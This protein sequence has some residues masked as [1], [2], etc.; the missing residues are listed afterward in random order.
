[1]AIDAVSL[2][3]R[4]SPMA[5]RA[6]PVRG[7]RGGERLRRTGP[8]SVARCRVALH[9][10]GP[11]D[12]AQ[13]RLGAATSQYIS[14]LRETAVAVLDDRGLVS[15]ARRRRVCVTT[16]LRPRPRRHDTARGGARLRADRSRG[17][18][19]RGS[20]LRHGGRPR[21]VRSLQLPRWLAD[22]LAH[23]VVAGPDTDR[24]RPDRL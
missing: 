16:A 14:V 17:G 3:A 13:R 10:G 19:A 7:R 23:A 1:M 6:E 22:L 9:A 4:I 24:S 5:A 2:A 20:R 21:D 12:A 18:A 15:P 8:T 11:R